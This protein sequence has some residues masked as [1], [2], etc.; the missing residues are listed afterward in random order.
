M[1]L[2]KHLP[3]LTKPARSLK[4]RINNLETSTPLSPTALLQ[5]RKHKPIS[6]QY[7]CGHVY[8]IGFITCWNGGTQIYGDIEEVVE[9]NWD[10]CGNCN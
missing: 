5:R 8:E 9:V 7:A 4:T 1:S 10:M 3:F 6:V 2:K